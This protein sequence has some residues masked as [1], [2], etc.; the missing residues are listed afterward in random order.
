MLSSLKLEQAGGNYAMVKKYIEHFQIDTA[1]F[2]G[3]AWNKGLKVETRPKRTLEEILARGVYYKSFELKQRLF[4]AGL[5]P[6]LCQECGWAERTPEGHLPLEIHHV[7]GDP[8]D[9]RLENLQIVC[10]NCHSLKPNYRN[11]VRKSV[12]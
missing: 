4:S 9:N 3:H 2:K 7:N 12:N 5:K 6:Q 8:C 10:P 11:R 1:H